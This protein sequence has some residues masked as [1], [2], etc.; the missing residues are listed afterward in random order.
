MYINSLTELPDYKLDHVPVGVRLSDTP[1][2]P[3]S[4][5]YADEYD[6]EK[7]QLEQTRDVVNQ[8]TQAGVIRNMLR[9][10][11]RPVE[12]RETLGCTYQTIRKWRIELKLDAS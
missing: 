3:P 4:R 8:K 12:I 11:F 10:G 1:K 5:D 9:Q 2:R 6:R 7:S